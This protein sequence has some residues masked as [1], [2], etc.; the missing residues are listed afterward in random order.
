MQVLNLSV[1]GCQCMEEESLPQAGGLNDS[2]FVTA[3]EPFHACAFT[4]V[5]AAVGG[6]DGAA[7][8]TPSMPWPTA[9]DPPGSPPP[10]SLSSKSLCPVSPRTPFLKYLFSAPERHPNPCVKAEMKNWLAHV[11][12]VEGGDFCA[13]RLTVSLLLAWQVSACC[14]PGTNQCHGCELASSFI[15]LTS[16]FPSLLRKKSYLW[17]W[18]RWPPYGRFCHSPWGLELGTCSL[19]KAERLSSSGHTQMCAAFKAAEKMLFSC[20]VLVFF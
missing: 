7:H 11:S 12:T 4:E 10:A 8:Q 1:S 20:S 17:T 15:T 3:P 5:S 14:N 2:G 13:C 19:G 18:T 6:L 16:S 9:W